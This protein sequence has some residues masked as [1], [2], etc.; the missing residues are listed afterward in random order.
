MSF[1]SAASRVIN[2]NFFDEAGT[3]EGREK[4]AAYGGEFIRDHL[5]EDSFARKIMNA[6]GIDPS[7]CQV[8]LT[9]D[10]LIRVEEIE[11]NSRAMAISFRGEP[12][13]RYIS[14]PRFAIGFFTISSEK[15]EKTEQE[16]LAYRMPITKVIEDNSVKDL[17]E[18]EDREFVVHLESMVEFLQTTVNGGV[19]AFN[20][21]NVL[22][23]AVLGGLDVNGVNRGGKIKGTLALAAAADD[24]VIRPVQ[25]PDFVNLF[26]ILT[27]KRLKPERVLITESDWAD[28]LQ[29]T[30]EDVGDKAQSETLVDGYKYNM[31][32]GMKF[33]RTIKNNILREGN[34][35]VFAAPEF[36]G[37][38]Y[39]LNEVKFYID[40]IANRL[41]WQCWED[42]GMGFGNIS[43][44]GK[45]E[46]YSGSITVGATTGGFAAAIPM[47]EDNLEITNNQ[48]AAGGV[49][50]Q[51]FIF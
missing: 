23:G 46:L 38:F 9:H 18:I 49:F 45:L 31:L 16:L 1:D 17:Q 3:A 10:T 11:P 4:L 2:S 35:Y 20:R 12:T 39:I 40:K 26:K 28:I 25:R 24:F 15:F 6:R 27:Q 19:V 33:I 8:S 14:A 7:A 50:P 51:V 30:T 47:A 13:A 48:V 22:A 43:A 5:R 34:I 37:F 21:T 44:V 32:L 36:F 42:I 41:M 29:W